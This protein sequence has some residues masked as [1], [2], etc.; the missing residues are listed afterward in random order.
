MEFNFS[1]FKEPSSWEMIWVFLSKGLTFSLTLT[2]TATLGGIF[3]GTILALMRLSNSRLLKWTAT[4]YVDIFR[5]I[6]LLMVLLWFFLFFKIFIGFLGIRA[7]FVTTNTIAVV[8]FVAFEAAYFSEIVRA[9]INSVSREQTYAG[10]AL[11]MTYRQNM[12]LIVLPQAF[13]NMV[14][15]TYSGHLTE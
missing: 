3:L 7:D 15:L 9:G 13:R 1:F 5:S 11:G 12:S 4:L 6:P 2:L 8:T 10:L 14:P